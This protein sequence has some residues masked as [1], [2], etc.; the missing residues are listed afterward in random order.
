[1]AGAAGDTAVAE[2]QQDLPRGSGTVEE[3]H[4]HSPAAVQLWDW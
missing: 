1:M 3:H 4:W 2:R